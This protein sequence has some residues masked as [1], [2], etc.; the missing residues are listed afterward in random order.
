MFAPL[1]LFFELVLHCNRDLS[2]DQ[3]PQKYNH[4]FTPIHESDNYFSPR[5]ETSAVSEFSPEKRFVFSN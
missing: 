2:K 1:P 3:S 5:D 4:A